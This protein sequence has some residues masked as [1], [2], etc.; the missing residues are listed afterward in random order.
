MACQKKEEVS[1]DIGPVRK[2]KWREIKER[3]GNNKVRSDGERIYEKEERQQKGREE[4]RRKE[5][6]GTAEGTINYIQILC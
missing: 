3:K 6:G 5:G 4:E 2:E 1:K